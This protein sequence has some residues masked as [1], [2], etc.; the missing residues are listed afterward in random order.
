MA[1]GKWDEIA[2]RRVMNIL[3]KSRVSTHRH[4]EIKISEAGPRNQRAEPVIISGAVKR[5]V[6]SG[7]VSVQLGSDN[8]KYF[9]PQD[10]GLPGDAS[11][12]RAFSSWH[13]K[14]KR[15]TENESLCGNVL[16][17]LT[18]DSLDLDDYEI[19]GSGPIYNDKG[20]LVKLPGSEQLF[21]NK[22]A[23]YKH[24]HGA[25]FDLLARH[26]DSNIY[27]GIECKNIRQWVYP[28]SQE[29]WRMIARA[30]T[31]ECLPVMVSRKI[32]FL[33]RAGLFSKV[34]ILGFSSQFQYF[35]NAV[36][37]RSKYTFRQD[38]IGKDRLGFADIRL[39]KPSDPAPKNIRDFFKHTLPENIEEYYDKFLGKKE[40]LQK[41]A[42]EKG[43]AENMSGK[44]RKQLYEEFKEE[45]EYDDANLWDEP[46]PDDD[47]FA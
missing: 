41:Y 17:R 27:L 9:V 34:G 20:V 37:A 1:Y 46:E 12:L 8:Q 7:E 29:V 38:I 42:I 21:L 47:P 32:S 36:N 18:S 25:G 33:S 43:L 40:L 39:I 2:E 13:G 24:E 30:C 31:L 22:R 3:T 14:F 15:Y 16:E 35:D 6:Q 4:L 28:D 19:F 5:M 10:F 44:K 11:R 45:A 23:I 26:R